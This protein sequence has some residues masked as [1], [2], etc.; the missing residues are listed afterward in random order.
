MATKKKAVKKVTTKK[1]TK[2]VAKK[3]IARPVNKTV[4]HSQTEH[5]RRQV[6]IGVKIIAVLDYIG[7]V[8][9]A[10]LGIFL[11]FASASLTEYLVETIE[12][13]ETFSAGIFIVMG[14]IMI[15]FAVLGFFVGRGLFRGEQWARIVEIIFA[16]LA[17]ISSISTIVQ[18]NAS[19]SGIIELIIYLVIGAYLLFSKEVN[20]AF[21]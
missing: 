12:G 18:G 17:V 15:A 7:A 10:I 5:R 2:K 1:T 4:V 16:V 8:I 19:F 6:P 20:K 11:I 21:A 13:I 14:I 3:V 9:L